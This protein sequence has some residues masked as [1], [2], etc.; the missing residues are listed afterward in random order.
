MGAYQT[1]FDKSASIS[2]NKRKKV[3]QTVSRD[4]TVKTTSLGGQTWQFEV[5]M[6]DGP[7]FTEMRPLIEQMEALDRVTTSTVQINQTG[8]SYITGYQGGLSN[9]TGVTVSFT[10]GTTLVITGGATLGSGYRFKAGDFIQLGTTGSVYTV[11][12]DVAY[13]NNS[14]TV[15]RPVREAAG[16]YTLKVGPNVVWNVVCTQF[17]KWTIFSRNQVSWDGPFIFAEAI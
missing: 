14:I 7:T 4:G 5:R 10:T 16:T 9:I 3:A 11:A 6:P 13:N 8:H 15:H 2:I 17:P 1:V 12:S